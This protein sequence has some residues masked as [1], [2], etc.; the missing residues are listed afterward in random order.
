MDSP[1]LAAE[2]PIV[3][4]DLRVTP[5]CVLLLPRDDVISPEISVVIP[6]M[7]E[8]LT[9]ADTVEWCK[10][11]FATA[12]VAGEV[13]IVDSSSDETPEIAL[14]HG[15]RVLKTPKRGLGRAYIDAIP[16][17]RAKFILMGDA[18]CTYDFRHLEGFVREFRR[19][20]EFIMGSRF[21][22]SIEEGAMPGLHRHFGTPITTAILNALYSSKFSDIHCGMRGITKEALQRIDLESQSWEYASE[23]VLKSVCLDLKTTEVPV[24]FLKD[25]EG[26]SSHMKRGGF[27]EPWRAGWINLRV[28]LVYRAD[29]FVLRPGLVLLL[30]GLLLSIPQLF[31]TIRIG[32][33]TLSLYWMLFGATLGVVGLQSFFLGCIVQVMYN[34]SAQAGRRWL[35]LF[36]Y[37]RALVITGFLALAGCLLVLPLARLYIVNGFQLPEETSRA[38]YMSVMGLF[39]IISAFMSFTSTLIIHAAALRRKAARH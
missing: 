4:E 32:P 27:L 26:R 17:I 33:I 1:S 9:I 21:K 39:L 37:T 38:N 23:M 19:G 7:N 30:L 36:S 10:E 29:L 24:H 3:E 14:A 12:G 31:G 13:L 15:A 35:Q 11:G 6:A 16:Y 25:R 2:F 8:R 34:Y 22:G 20:Y 18:D 5:E 28:M